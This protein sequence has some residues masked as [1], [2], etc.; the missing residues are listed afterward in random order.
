MIRRLL[1]S[2]TADTHLTV[3]AVS[4][5]S[6]IVQI[7]RFSRLLYFHFLFYSLSV[8]IFHN[9]LTHFHW[10]HWKCVLMRYQRK[11]WLLSFSFLT[12]SDCNG[13]AGWFS[14][15]HKVYLKSIEEISLSSSKESKR[16][17]IDIMM[18]KLDERKKWP[19]KFVCAIAKTFYYADLIHLHILS[20]HLRFVASRKDQIISMKMMPKSTLFIGRGDAIRERPMQSNSKSSNANWWQKNEHIIQEKE[21]VKTIVSQLM[22]RWFDP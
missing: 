12:L 2:Y 8:H 19:M 4:R 18:R 3:T 10:S 13:M 22:Q 20:I 17:A 21:K 7:H 1:R 14:E 16:Q 11:Q 15:Q 9:K 6:S 5:G